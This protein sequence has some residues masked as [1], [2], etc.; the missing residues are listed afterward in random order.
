MVTTFVVIVKSVRSLSVQLNMKTFSRWKNK[1]DTVEDDI[2]ERNNSQ[3]KFF[4]NALKIKKCYHKVQKQNN[5]SLAKQN[6]SLSLMYL[7]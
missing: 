4:W 1:I 3:I 2:T 5:F 6:K 7:S